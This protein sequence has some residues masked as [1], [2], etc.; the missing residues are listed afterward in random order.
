VHDVA[1]PDVED[2]RFINPLCDKEGLME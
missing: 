2:S 1:S